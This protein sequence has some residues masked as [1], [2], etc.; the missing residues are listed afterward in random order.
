[1]HAAALAHHL[2]VQHEL[3]PIID[4]GRLPPPGEGFARF[5]RTA[6]VAKL[7]DD[8]VES[9]IREGAGDPYDSHPPLRER[10]A[11]L[12]GVADPEQPPDDRLSIEL[13]AN[14]ERLETELLASMLA[15]NVE[16]IAWSDT[17]H[18]W[19]Q[20]WRALVGRLGKHVG[21]MTI[22]TIPSSLAPLHDL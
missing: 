14:A 16:P 21:T 7:L 18:V 3:G 11:A 17:A 2:Y 12:A 15:K 9:E 19:E 20:R 5:L 6:S 22:A 10:I 8:A 13:V 1:T 4:Q